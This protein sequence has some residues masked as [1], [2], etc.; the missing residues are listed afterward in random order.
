MKRLYFRVRLKDEVK[1]CKKQPQ[2]MC[3]SIPL[4]RQGSE[5][6]M[7]MEGRSQAYQD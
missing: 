1:D 7:L 6:W 2:Q 3:Q 5:A 4:A